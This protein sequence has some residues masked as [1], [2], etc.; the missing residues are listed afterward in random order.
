MVDGIRRPYDGRRPSDALCN[1]RLTPLRPSL[2][3]AIGPVRNGAEKAVPLAAISAGGRLYFT[4]ADGTDG[5]DSPLVG[6]ICRQLRAPRPPDRLVAGGVLR[7][8][9]G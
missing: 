9:W 7:V 6:P 5:Y 2:R 1:E 4:Q 3:G 8:G